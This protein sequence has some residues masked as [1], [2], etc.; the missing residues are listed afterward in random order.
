MLILEGD[1]QGGFTINRNEYN[2]ATDNKAISCLQTADGY[3]MYLVSS[4]SGNLK[5]YKPKQKSTAILLA[6]EDVYAVIKY[7]NGKSSKSEFQFGNSYLSQS[8][9]K[10]FISPEVK[11]ITIFTVAGSKRELTFDDHQ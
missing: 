11:A 9:R 1:G 7:N 8:S 5:A 6:D 10:L 4:N 2:S 3:Q